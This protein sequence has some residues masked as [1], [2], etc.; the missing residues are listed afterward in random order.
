MSPRPPRR[1]TRSDRPRWAANPRSL[2]NSR[3]AARA[4][5][6]GISGGSVSIPIV[7]RLVGCHDLNSNLPEYAPNFRPIEYINATVQPTV[8]PIVG[9]YFN[10]KS[11]SLSADEPLQ[12]GRSGGDDNELQTSGAQRPPTASLMGADLSGLSELEL[13]R[14]SAAQQMAVAQQKSAREQSS[15]MSARPKMLQMSS[16]GLSAAR[17]SQAGRMDSARQNRQAN[18]LQNDDEQLSL[19]IQMRNQLKPR[20]QQP[21]LVQRQ[22]P[23]GRQVQSEPSMGGALFS[24]QSLQQQQHQMVDYSEE[25]E[26][27]LMVDNVGGAESDSRTRPLDSSSSSMM[28]PEQPPARPAPGRQDDQNV[29]MD[30]VIGTT[31]QQQQPAASTTPVPTTATSQ[32]AATGEVAS[33]TQA[34]PSTASKS[35]GG[36]EETAPSGGGSTVG[37]ELNETPISIESDSSGPEQNSNPAANMNEGQQQ[38]TVTTT[39]TSRPTTAPEK[40]RLELMNGRPVTEVRPTST[41]SSARLPSISTQT[42]AP[43]VRTTP[44]GQQPTSTTQPSTTAAPSTTNMSTPVAS[45]STNTTSQRGESQTTSTMAPPATSTIA[46]GAQ[47]ASSN[48]SS[49]DK[50]TTTSGEA[51]EDDQEDSEEESEGGSGG[52]GNLM[53][54][55]GE[56]SASDDDSAEDSSDEGEEGAAEQTT[57]TMRPT[58]AQQQTST[59]TQQPSMTTIDIERLPKGGQSQS[60]ADSDTARLKTGEA[61]NNSSSRQKAPK[62]FVMMTLDRSRGSMEGETAIAIPMDSLMRMMMNQKTVSEQLERLMGSSAAGEGGREP[63][64]TTTQSAT[65]EATTTRPATT[66]TTNSPVS[67]S[68]AAEDEAAGGA[69]TTAKQRGKLQPPPP[70]TRMPPAQSQTTRQDQLQTTQSGSAQRVSTDRD[71][72]SAAV[73]S[74]ESEAGVAAPA[75]SDE[76]GG[77]EAKIEVLNMDLIPIQRLMGQQQQQPDRSGEVQKV[78]QETRMGQQQQQQATVLEVEPGMRLRPVQMQQTKTNGQ[79]QMPNRMLNPPNTVYMI[80][81]S[82]QSSVSQPAAAPT[83]MRPAPTVQQTMTTNPMPIEQPRQQTSSSPRGSTTTSAASRQTQ[84]QFQSQPTTKTQ[85]QSA[86]GFTP[87]LM[88]K[89]MMISQQQ[90]QQISG[91]SKSGGGSQRQQAAIMA[92]ASAAQQTSSSAASLTNNNPSQ[93]ADS[94]S[95]ARTSATGRPTPARTSMSSAVDVKQNEQMMRMVDAFLMATQQQSSNNIQREFPNTKPLM[96][97]DQPARSTPAPAAQSSPFATPSAGSQSERSSSPSAPVQKMSSSTGAASSQPPA[98]STSVA[99]PTTTTAA[100]TTTTT[101]PTTT[102]TTL[103][104][105]TA[106]G[107]TSPRQSI[108]PTTTTGSPLL[109]STSAQAPSVGP[110]RDAAAPSRGAAPSSVPSTTPASTPASTLVGAVETQTQTAPPKTSFS[111]KTSLSQRLTDAAGGK[112]VGKVDRERARQQ[113]QPTRRPQAGKVNTS[114]A[115]NSTSSFIPARLRNDFSASNMTNQPGGQQQQQR[116]KEASAKLIQSQGQRLEGSATVSPAPAAASSAAATTTTTTQSPAAVAQSMAIRQFG[117]A[118]R[119]SLLANQP[120]PFG[121][122]SAM[123]MLQTNARPASSKTLVE[124]PTFEYGPSI[125]VRR[126]DE[127]LANGQVPNCTLTGKNFC[128]LT[129]DYPMNE[130]RQAVERSFRSVRIMYEELQTVSD[131]ELHKEDFNAT[132]NR[133][134]SGTFACQT[135]TMTMKPGWAKDEITKEWMLI[136]NTDVFPQRVRTESCVQPNAPCEFIAPFYDSTCQQRYSLHRMIAIDPHDPSRSPQVTVFKFPAG[137]VCRVNPIRKTSATTLA[138]TTPLSSAPPSN[139]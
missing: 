131:Q 119:M 52:A 16:A 20:Q 96:Q 124:V 12:T 26:P 105:T 1:T 67:A 118:N 79:Q 56:E 53:N 18:Q 92:P 130:V 101:A 14:N 94:A 91:L 68:S 138:P 135:Q 48:S 113:L 35:D 70:T 63:G 87:A 44:G 11:I 71:G 89:P 139:R 64:P 61:A 110:S 116:S 28:M 77:R 102:T 41:T 137:C 32:R 42:Q 122:P 115:L 69:I 15:W 82:N 125:A 33:T 62:N 47:P 107:Q 98:T 126:P 123:T 59:T 54:S 127:A 108:R 93:P 136:V 23:V 38:T 22:L 132:N 3:A 58:S 27:E 40:N 133:A 24:E 80:M 109:S 31:R 76:S 5:T 2:A 128:V 37:V 106:S 30:N 117:G 81:M 121:R 50:S 66:T 88:M 73:P 36:R 120:V 95:A 99:P 25:G 13:E 43:T 10:G 49:S 17:A 45:E 65:S 46:E 60:G 111:D 4:A 90:Q 134:A 75:A 103:A 34:P 74:S 19:G 51:E 84:S 100:S 21:D 114:K 86:S 57:T 129:K 8:R 112:E 55:A 97:T 39:T 83:Q 78:K 85:Q 9:V 72:I 7:S 6:G 29:M 104:T